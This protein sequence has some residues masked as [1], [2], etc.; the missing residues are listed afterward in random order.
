[1]S[2]L[3]DPRACD[4]DNPLEIWSLF[5]SHMIECLNNLELIYLHKC[6]SL[7]VIFKLEGL[8][9]EQSHVAPV[10]DQLRKLDLDNLPKLMHIWKKGPDQ[11]MGFKNLKL[12]EVKECNSLTYL[13]SPSIA[14]LL[15][16][17]EEIKVTNCEKM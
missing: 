1:M 16:M 15:V 5:P 11:I 13:F 6:D 9:D 10:Q 17:L 4:I 12:L 3:K 14:K 7:E 8:N 2:K